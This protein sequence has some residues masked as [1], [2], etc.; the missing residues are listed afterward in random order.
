MDTGPPREA[1]RG[2]DGG[3]GSREQA[4]GHGLEGGGRIWRSTALARGKANAGQRGLLFLFPLWLPCGIWKF[5]SQGPDPSQ[6]LELCRRPQLQKYQTLYPLCWAGDR[7]CTPALPRCCRSVAPQQELS[8]GASIARSWYRGS[9]PGPETV[10][11]EDFSCCCEGMI[12]IDA[13]TCQVPWVH[14]QP[15]CSLPHRNLWVLA[16]SRCR[17]SLHLVLERDPGL[18]GVR[19]WPEGTTACSTGRATHQGRAVSPCGPTTVLQGLLCS[20]VSRK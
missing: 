3:L 11:M 2:Q 14:L 7:T 16:M 19:A 17:L 13:E 15:H 6:S 18:A 10:L 5:P 4:P 8:K 12:L 9:G 1:H 20:L